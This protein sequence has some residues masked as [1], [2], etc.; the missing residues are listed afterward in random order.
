MIPPPF[1]APLPGNSQS[2]I[3][4]WYSGLRIMYQKGNNRKRHLNPPPTTPSLFGQN[5][6]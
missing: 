5:Q 4:F 3:L 2:H 6:T 1:I